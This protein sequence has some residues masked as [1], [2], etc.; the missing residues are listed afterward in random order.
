MNDPG[1]LSGLVCAGLLCLIGM[2]LLSFTRRHRANLR[3]QQRLFLIALASRFAFAVVTYQFGLVSVLGDEDASGWTG[4]V[5]LREA[6]VQQGVTPFDL[7]FILAEAFA[8]RNEGYHFLLGAFFYLTGAPARLPA[9]ALNAFFGAATVVFAYRVARALFSAWVARKVGW[10]TCFFPSMIVW[11]ALTVKEPVVIFLETVALYACVALRRGTV[12]PRHL[13]LCVAAVAAL[14]TFR[15]YAAYVVTVAV[16]VSLAAPVLFRPRKAMAGVAL[17]A[18]FV[19]LALVTGALARH[20]SQ[21]E[22]LRLDRIQTFR[23]N[24]S[25]GG[26]RWGSRSGVQTADVRTSSGLIQ[27]VVIGAAHLL[28]APFPWQLG[29]ASLRLVLTLPELLF[30]WWLFFV[31]VLPGA[32]HVVRRRLADVAPMLLFLLGFGL[33]YSLMF[34]NLGLV[35]RQRTQ[36]LPWLL[37]FAAVGLEQQMLWI[38]AARARRPVTGISPQREETPSPAPGEMLRA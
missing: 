32:R 35:L 8:R 6:W 3:W 4:G 19:P 30:W 15:F 31:G 18:L 10:F 25:T 21:F 38:R 28:L 34:G 22:R 23:Q 29:G 26:E 27:G 2:W 14:L 5:G 13:A 33:L 7:P 36:L 9:A 24:V 17:L 11:S 12:S 37:I 20:E 1:L 16:V